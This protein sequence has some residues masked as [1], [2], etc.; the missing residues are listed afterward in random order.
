MLKTAQIKIG[1]VIGIIFVVYLM[2]MFALSW[3]SKSSSE[4]I[5]EMRERDAVNEAYDIFN[6]ILNN[7]NL[8]Y[9]VRGLTES[10]HT[11]DLINLMTLSRNIKNHREYY[12]RKLG[13]SEIVIDLYDFRNPSSPYVNRIVVYNNTKKDLVNKKVYFNLMNVYSPLNKTFYLGVMK[14]SVSY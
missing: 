2:L 1:E 3:F 10:S 12:P 9:K 6:F 11:L 13:Y 4:T 5:A 14:V 8:Q 7:P